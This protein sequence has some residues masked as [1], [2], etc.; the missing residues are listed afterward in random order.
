MKTI[1][2]FLITIL[3]IIAIVGFVTGFIFK[4]WHCFV[5]GIFASLLFGEL[6]NPKN[7]LR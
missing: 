1:K 3:V 6:Y 5:I 4:V 7:D 2:N